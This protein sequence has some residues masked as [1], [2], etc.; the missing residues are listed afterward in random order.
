MR[1]RPTLATLA[2]SIGLIRSALRIARL[3]SSRSARAIW[4]RSWSEWVTRSSVRL[5][6]DERAAQ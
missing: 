2:R 6:P 1:P 4:V 3:A 5:S